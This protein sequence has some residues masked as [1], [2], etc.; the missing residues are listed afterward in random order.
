MTTNHNTDVLQSSDPITRFDFLCSV[1]ANMNMDVARAVENFSAATNSLNQALL[2]ATLAP[3][4]VPCKHAQEPRVEIPDELIRRA[5][6]WQGVSMDYVHYLL[7]PVFPE[8]PRG[9]GSASPQHPPDGRRGFRGVLE[10]SV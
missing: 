6:G 10:A 9:R 1:N 3:N 5:Q 2:A 4:A 7:P 8:D